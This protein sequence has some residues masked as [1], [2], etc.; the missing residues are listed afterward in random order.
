[1]GRPLIADSIE[2]ARA[3]GLFEVVA[4]SSD[5]DAILAAAADAGADICIPRPAELATD[6]APKLLAV[7]HAVRF[8]EDQ[9]DVRFDVFV[10]LDAT[11]PLRTVAD[12]EAAVD[13]LES[14]DATNVIT[15]AP[16][17][18]SPYFNMVELNDEGVPQLVRRDSGS[19]F[20]RQTVPA[21]YD[22][23]ASVYVWR[24]EALFEFDGVFLSRTRLY[25]MPRERSVDIDDELDFVTVELLMNRQRNDANGEDHLADEH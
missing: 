24:R 9:R 3:S 13:L 1:M 23:N 17:R 5:S 22:M 7:R 16:A 20:S 21:C 15:A 10:D 18:H 19:Y 14:T 6:R 2:R 8:V 12:I 11:S 4:V 25:V